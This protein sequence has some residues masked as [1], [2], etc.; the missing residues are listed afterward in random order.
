M[1]IF[2]IHFNMRIMINRNPGS[3]GERNPFQVFALWLVLSMTLCIA[4]SLHA[5]NYLVSFTGSGASSVVTAVH[6]TNLSR[7]TTAAVYGSDTLHLVPFIGGIHTMEEASPDRLLVH[8][9]PVSGDC[10]LSFY[11]SG[12]ADVNLI[13]YNLSGE[14]M[15]SNA[16]FLPAGYQTYRISGLKQGVY[17][18]HVSSG[19]FSMSSKI[20]SMATEGGLPAV[21]YEGGVEPGHHLRK[22]STSRGVVQMEYADG[23]MLLL[24]GFVTTCSRIVTL[25]PAGNLVVDFHFIPCTDHDG[26]HYPVVSIGGQTW[27]A[28]NLQSLQ[29][30]NGEPIPL[31]TGYAA[32]SM[33]TTPAYCFYDNDQNT[34]GP[35]YG[36]L[37]NHYAVARGNVCPAGWHVPSD[38][39]WTLLSDH[40]GGL[41]LA[42][43]LMKATGTAKW[44]SPNTGATNASG[45]TA[46]PG[47]NRSPGGGVFS[48]S[49]LSGRFWS[50]SETDAVSA[51]DR[52][53]RYDSGH[54]SR[55]ISG[56]ATGAYIRCVLNDSATTLPIPSPDFSV[57]DTAVILTDTVYFTDLSLNNPTSWE[58]SFGDG[59]TSALQNPAHRY[60]APGIY[61]VTL[62]A[63]NT[64]GFDTIVRINHITVTSP[65]GLYPVYDTDGNGYD[66]VHIGSQVWLSSNLRTTRFNNGT[67]IPNVT[68]NSV[69]TNLST[70]GMCWYDNDSATWANVCGALY[71]WFAVADGNLCPTGWHV[72]TDTDWTTLTTFY[73]G[74][75][76]AGGYLKEAGFAHWN[77]PNAGAINTSGFT[78]LPGGRRNYATGAFY[79][80]GDYGYWWTSTVYFSTA[81]YRRMRFD[82]MDV[83]RSY[84]SPKFGFSVRCVSD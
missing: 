83:L 65:V 11:M 70:P 60:A 76:L 4:G 16:Q 41:S 30:I 12:P 61:T 49:G 78:A 58:W 19:R 62:V 25:V 2:T 40:L 51:Y 48:G 7:G 15:V 29:Y 56:K 1:I 27:M 79:E 8:P 17:L 39:E 14:K 74:T 5:Q 35:M 73:G 80:S 45:F 18:V 9:N 31:E 50:S 52:N 69:W 24:R 71:N 59:K 82:G 43:G 66:T 75:S 81:W 47:G 68:V 22:P 33:L 3:K 44:F 6:V 54:L 67:L 77:T 55:N 63:A 72:A 57:S 23:E 53:L 64:W 28:E 26:N 10:R 34:Y 42:G 21:T 37:Y 46:L 36:T 13:L 20:I 84:Y 38:G 32:W